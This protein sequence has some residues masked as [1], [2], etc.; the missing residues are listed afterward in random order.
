LGTNLL[1]VSPGSPT[2][3]NVRFG[4]GASNALAS[5]DADAITATV[6]GLSGISP[7][8]TAREQVIAG[9]QNTNTSVIGATD[10]YVTVHNAPVAF[11]SFI[12][13]ANIAALDKVAVLGPQTLATLFPNDPN[14]LGKDIR[15]GNT[16]F[17]VIGVM[18]TKGSQGIA[19]QDDRIL[20]PLSTMQ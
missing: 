10:A 14:P 1:T 3:T 4:G 12:T 8:L 9:S 17:T 6:T 19:N 7:E 18:Q 2:Q 5:T 15:I 20:V 11:G 16:I 13:Q